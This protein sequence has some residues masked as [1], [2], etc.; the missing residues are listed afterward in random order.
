MNRAQGLKAQGTKKY[1]V[2]SKLVIKRKESVAT[3]KIDTMIELE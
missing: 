2:I 1:G 3:S